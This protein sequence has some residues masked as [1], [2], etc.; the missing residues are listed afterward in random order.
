MIKTV[1][2][3]DEERARHTLTSIIDNF[4]TGVE[5]VATASSVP[6]GVLAIN[7]YQPDLVLLDIEMP[8][9]NGFELFDFIKDI[10]FEVV[11]VT[12]YSE[13]A[14]RAF[15]VSAVD[16]IL[17]PVEIE[18][19]QHAIEKVSKRLSSKTAGKRVE[20]LKE[21]YSGELNKIALPVS[22][23]LLF[24][25]INDIVTLEAEGAYTYVC[26]KDGNKI[27]ISKKLKF[28]EDLL[29]ERPLFYRPHRSYLINLS[30]INKYVRGENLLILHDNI[31]ITIARD[32][33]NEFELYLKEHKIGS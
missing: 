27:L 4:C 29:A 25:E 33:K 24:I 13:F 2:I 32:K 11:F 5:V 23:G 28:F 18:Q 9:Y 12:A 3:D 31:H 14:L 22:D 15:E 10:Q 26:L 17:K 21:A 20:V 6:E 8:E 7:K 30:Y 1:I 19:L 16:Y